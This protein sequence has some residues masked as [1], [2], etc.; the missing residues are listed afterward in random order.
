MA[1]RPV[2]ITTNPP[3]DFTEETD[4]A[5]GRFGGEICYAT[6]DWFAPAENM[7]NH[8]APVFIE[9]KFTTCGKWMDG[10]ESRRKR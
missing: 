7:L 4:L 2:P 9:E 6:D 5:L 3:P 8:E 10:W 1:D